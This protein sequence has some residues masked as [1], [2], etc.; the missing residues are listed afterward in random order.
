MT[1]KQKTTRK[2]FSLLGK[3]HQK[4]FRKELPFS[5]NSVLGSLSPDYVRTMTQKLNKEFESSDSLSGSESGT[6]QSSDEESECKYAMNSHEG[7]I[8]F[9]TLLI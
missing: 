8:N 1:E 4:M 9:K 6:Y 7:R 5:V 2:L 3:L